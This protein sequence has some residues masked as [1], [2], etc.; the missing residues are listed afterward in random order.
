[1]P[2]DPN[3]KN[4]SALFEPLE[5]RTLL[6]WGPI[7]QLIDQD[8]AVA[9]Y[10]QYNGA[11]QT[12]AFIDTGV[13]YNHP[14]LTG[15]YIGGYDFLSNNTHPPPTPRPPPRPPPLPLRNNLPLHPPPFPS[16]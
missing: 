16:T 5:R 9:N 15:K 13:D 8:L 7:P 1:M 4:K 6:A 3:L 10:G 12:I 2:Y 14:A 11:G